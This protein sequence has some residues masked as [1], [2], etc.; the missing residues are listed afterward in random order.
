MLQADSEKLRQAWV[1]AVQASIASAYRESPD[2]CYSEVWLHMCCGERA[3]GL[4]A[5]MCAHMHVCAWCLCECECV[6]MRVQACAP[7]VLSCAGTSVWGGRAGLLGR[8]T[9]APVGLN[10]PSHIPRGW[11]VRHPRPPA[12]STQPQTLGSAARVRVCCSACRT[13]LATASV[14][15]AVSQTPAGPASTWA[16][17]SASSAQ[18]STGGSAGGLGGV[19]WRSHSD[20]PPPCRPGVWVSTAPRCGP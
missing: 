6:H 2:S 7:G 14:E 20:S 10:G 18:A 13:W 16:C 5:G 12:A 19:P 17:C 1:Q 8:Q 11:T 3:S 15:T 4:H 9:P